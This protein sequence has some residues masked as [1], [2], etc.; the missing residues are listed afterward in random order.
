MDIGN[1]GVLHLSFVFLLG[2]VEQDKWRNMSVMTNGFGGRDKSRVTLKRVPV[3]PAP[4]KL[5]T[6]PKQEETTT[7][8]S[9]SDA[10]Q[11]DEEMVD[12]K[13]LAASSAPMPIDTAPKR[14]IVRLDINFVDLQFIS[15]V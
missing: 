6:P 11:S 12:V 7:T 1:G 4:P 9:V 2:L 15:T 3:Q 5:E 14:S 10:P 13:P 8:T